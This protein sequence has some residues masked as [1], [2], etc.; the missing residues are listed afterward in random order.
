MLNVVISV[1]SDSFDRVRMTKKEHELKTRSEMLH[2]YALFLSL[3]CKECTEFGHIYIWRQ[4]E[5]GKDNDD[6]TGK[7]NVV[8]NKMIKE[9]DKLR[10]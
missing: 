3:F 10:V 8:M 7:V 1:V 9:S 4:T 6:W 5:F 2:E